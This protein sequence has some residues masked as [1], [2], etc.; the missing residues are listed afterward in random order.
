[1]HGYGKVNNTTRMKVVSHRE[2]EGGDICVEFE[3]PRKKTKGHKSGDCAPMPWPISRSTS[4]MPKDEAKHYPVG[5]LADIHCVPVKGGGKKPKTRFGRVQ[6]AA[7]A[8]KR[9]REEYEEE[10]E[11]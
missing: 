11:G 1:M 5:S 8:S 4:V 6:A 2:E 9:A 7:E 10:D 3:V